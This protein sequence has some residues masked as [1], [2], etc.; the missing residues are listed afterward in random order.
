MKEVDLLNPSLWIFFL[1]SV[2]IQS[3]PMITVVNCIVYL[4]VI[5]REDFKNPDHRHKIIIITLEY[6]CV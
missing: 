1:I 5:K 6:I 3:N 4:K 2:T